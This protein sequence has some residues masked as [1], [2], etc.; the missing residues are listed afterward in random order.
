MENFKEKFNSLITEKLGG[1][2]EQLTPDAR[3][4]LDLGAVSLDMV[5]LTMEFEKEF[6]ITIPD[7]D[8]DEI[9]TVSDAEKYILNL[10]NQKENN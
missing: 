5:E 4:T 9:K 3:F 7:D 6:Q 2:V 10:I 8:I 1:K